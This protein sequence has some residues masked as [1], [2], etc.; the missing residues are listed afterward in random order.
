MQFSEQINHRIRIH[1]TH[2][3]K[4]QCLG[5][6]A[7]GDI[8]SYTRPYYRVNPGSSSSLGRRCLSPR[9]PCINTLIHGNPGPSHRPAYVHMCPACRVNRGG[10]R[11]GGGRIHSCRAHPNNIYLYRSEGTLHCR[12]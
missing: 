6:G 5:A 2:R 10:G 8:F 9:H 1:H 12:H 4:M 7:G 3:W 11:S